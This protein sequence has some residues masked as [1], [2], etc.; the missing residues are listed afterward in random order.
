MSEKN[1]AIIQMVICSMMWSIAGILFRFIDCNPFVIAG[2]RSFFSMITVLVFM[3]ISKIKIHFTKNSMASALFLCLTYFAFV[4]ANKLTTAANAIVLQF[5]SPVFIL[6]INFFIFKKKVI[7]ADVLT[8]IL[9][10]TGIALFFF[11]QMDSGKLAGNIVGILSGVFVAAMYVS[12]GESKDDE[13]MSGILLGH[14][15]TAVIG[16]AFTPFTQNTLDLN[17]FFWLV[18]L[19]VVQLGIPYILV[20][21]ALKSCPPLACCLIG[22]IEPLLNPLWVFLIDGEIPGTM[23]FVGATV[24]LITITVWCIYKGR[25]GEA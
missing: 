1:K 7:R 4:S 22:V 3:K 13:R 23:S 8:V 19:G 15:I 6:L 16:I 24:I 17:A 20:G 12:C 21:L 11:D 2:W 25:I 18:V 9:T 5:T 10:L 14:I